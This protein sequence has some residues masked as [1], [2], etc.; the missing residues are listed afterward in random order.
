LGKQE[1]LK[2]Q[3][4]QKELMRK[5]YTSQSAVEKVAAKIPAGEY[6]RS[7]IVARNNYTRL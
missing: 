3:E 6:S 4:E 1:A 2:V 5:P 7:M